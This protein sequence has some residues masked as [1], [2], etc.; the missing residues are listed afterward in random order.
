VAS[1]FVNFSENLW[2]GSEK[3]IRKEIGVAG[4]NESKVCASTEKNKSAP[5]NM[6][7]IRKNKK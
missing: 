1:L 2:D 4:R 3:N 5:K 6:M 7:K